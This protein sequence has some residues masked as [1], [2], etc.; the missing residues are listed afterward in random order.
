MISIATARQ[1]MQGLVFFVAEKGNEPE[2]LASGRSCGGYESSQAEREAPAHL[3]A[4]AIGAV[5]NPVSHRGGVLTEL[6]E[7]QDQV[8]LASHLLRIVDARRP[9]KPWQRPPRGQDGNSGRDLAGK[10]LL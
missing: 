3:F 10:F 1:G 8:M 6:R 9:A 7:A 4:G 5:R 2:S